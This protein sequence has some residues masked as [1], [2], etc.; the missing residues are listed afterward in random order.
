LGLLQV[1]TTWHLTIHQDPAVHARFERL[2]ER[3]DARSSGW[4]PMRRSD[5]E[6]RRSPV[7]R[8]CR[9]AGARTIRAVRRPGARAARWSFAGESATR[10][11]YPAPFP[12]ELPRRLI[13][14]LSFPGDLVLDPFVG[15]GTTAE[16]ALILGRR[17]YGCDLNPIAVERTR[18]RMTRR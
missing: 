16:A 10:V 3:I 13:K 4:H 6:P 15:T 2:Q 12:I 8:D 11:G 17:F 5:P 7:R 14:L 9:L 18:L 1:C